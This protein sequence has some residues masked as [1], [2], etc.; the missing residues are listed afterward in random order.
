M[1]KIRWGIVGPGGIAHKFAEAI[2]NT[3]CAVLVGVASRDCERANEFAK[4]YAIPTVFETYEKMAASD[5][6]D[7]VYVSTVHTQHYPVAKMLLGSK[8]HVLCEKP[9]C[10]NSDLAKDLFETARKQGVFLM[11]AMWTACLPSVRALLDDINDGA[12]GEIRALSADFCYDIEKSEDPKLFEKKMAGG[13]LLDVGVYCIH[14]ASLV[15]GEPV[16]C[17]AASDIVDGVDYHT[18]MNFKYKNGAIA[19]L[20]SAIKAEKPYSAYVYGTNGYI[21]VPNFYKADRYE[22]RY[23][24]GKVLTKEFP[25]GENGFE[26]EITEACRCIAENCNESSLVPLDSTVRVLEQMD[27]VRKH[28]G[29]SF[30]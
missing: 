8:K 12:I 2:K 4:E 17:S 19:T 28:I 20:S 26:F 25:Y 1:K 16:E 6:I 7:A 18:V 9:M 21:Y 13:S 22:I 3:D 23:K 15:L 27:R 24:D 10:I 29:L 11:E 30:E 5:I 14:F